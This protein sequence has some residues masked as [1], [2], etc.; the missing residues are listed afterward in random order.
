MSSIASLGP[1]RV[2]LATG[3]LMLGYALSAPVRLSAYFFEKPA[4]DI[5]TDALLIIGMSLVCIKWVKN[6]APWS[7]V[8][9]PF[10]ALTWLSIDF[11]L[12]SRSEWW[13]VVSYLFLFTWAIGFSSLWFYFKQKLDRRKHAGLS[14]LL[15]RIGL[16][17]G[18]LLSPGL[19]F[20]AGLGTFFLL[21]LV[22][23]KINPIVKKWSYPERWAM[24][25]FIV[26]LVLQS[27]LNSPT[28]F[29]SQKRHHDKVIFSY[30]TR[31]QTLD[32]TEWKGN[33][34]FYQDNINHYSS[35]D[36]W[37]YYEPFV[38][39]VMQ[40]AKDKRVLIIGGENGMIAHHLKPYNPAS[41]DLLPIDGEYLE[42]ASTNPL[43]LAQN[44]EVFNRESIN[45]IPDDPFRWLSRLE[46]AYDVIF[47]DVPDPIDIELNQFY[48]R[49]FYQLA[50][51]A[52]SESGL[53][54]TQSGSPYFA[55]AA[56]Q[57][58]ERT[59]ESPG[60]QVVSFHNQVLSLGEWGW[61]LGSKSQSNLKHKLAQI[62]FE[63]VETQWLNTEAMQTM[64]SFGKPYVSLEKVEINTIANPVIYRLYNQGNYQLN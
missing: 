28:F 44:E 1:W 59:M 31:F 49:E 39:P 4:I 60:F 18:L 61:T 50:H 11:I 15:L 12:Y 64:L 26:P 37:L 24:A 56:F 19:L 54:V 25:F 36:S 46:S 30:Q 8:L 3:Y 17:V 41:I 7:I 51:A 62:S 9:I 43:Y 34:W 58:I 21:M 40:L 55:T 6:K 29:E 27:Q 20:I 5:I 52:L 2:A 10:L 22:F 48:T 38:H 23:S 45:V 35:I 57:S 63:G 53:M 47:V 16:A 13:S 14:A 42:V 32:V 33:H